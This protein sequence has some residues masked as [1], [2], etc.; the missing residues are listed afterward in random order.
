MLPKYWRTYVRELIYFLK[1]DLKTIFKNLKFNVKCKQVLCIIY[2]YY[3]Q[4]ETFH[5]IFKQDRLIIDLLMPLLVSL[6]SEL[7]ISSNNDNNF[8]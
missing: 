2:E 1:L 5:L 4:G 8:S 3:M 6:H 7:Q